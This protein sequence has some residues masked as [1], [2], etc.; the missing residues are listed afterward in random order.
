VR[1]TWLLAS[2]QKTNL[3]SCDSL[4]KPVHEQSSVKE[5]VQIW[6]SADKKCREQGNY[7]CISNHLIMA[8]GVTYLLVSELLLCLACPGM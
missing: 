5:L 3:L 7:N 2:L 6:P 8:A 1:T 4:L